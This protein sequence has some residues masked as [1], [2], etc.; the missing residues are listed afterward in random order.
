MPAVSV[1]IPVFNVEKYLRECLDSVCSQTLKDIEII[2]IDDGSTDSSL[3][4][5]NEYAEKD[6]RIRII[7]QENKGPSSARNTGIDNAKGKYVY[8]MDSDDYIEKDAMEKLYNIGEA[9]SIDCIMFK[10]IKFDDETREKYPSRYYDMEFV[11]DIVGDRVFSYEDIGGDLFFIPVSPQGKFF[12]REFLTDIRF[13]EGII[14]EDNPFFTEVLLKA[15]RLYFCDEYLCNRRIRSG[16]L[17][18]S[19]KNFTDYIIVSNRLIDLAKKYGC[20][21]KFKPQLYEKIFKNLF[22][23][24]TE[25]DEDNKQHFLDKLQEDFQY[26]IATQV[27]DA[28]KLEVQI[29]K[30]YEALKLLL[31][32]PE[33]AESEVLLAIRNIGMELDEINSLRQ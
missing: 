33:W 17:M 28:K 26:T 16:S 25:V 14:F 12:N 3:D 22:I 5:I 8:C 24:F 27:K 15:E 19:K 18:T 6:E 13:E 21:E 9:N 20:Y 30:K 31:Q 1:I 4:I 7:T 10:L 23:R 32:Q 2:C 11:K 29:E